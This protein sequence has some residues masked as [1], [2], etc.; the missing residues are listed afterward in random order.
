VVAAAGSAFATRACLQNR[1]S[2]HSSASKPRAT[3]TPAASGLDLATV[4][5]IALDHGGEVGLR[6]RKE[7]GL[8]IAVTLPMAGD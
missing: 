4:R 3:A 5:A 1:R 7:G 2:N 6:N 8:R